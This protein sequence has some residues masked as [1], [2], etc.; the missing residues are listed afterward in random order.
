VIFERNQI[1]PPCFG[2]KFRKT[3][4]FQ[5]QVFKLLFEKTYTQCV[6]IEV[7]IPVLQRKE[8]Q[9]IDVAK[10]QFIDC[11]SAVIEDI[12]MEMKIGDFKYNY[13]YHKRYLY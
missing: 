6:F 7:N 4:F 8:I 13:T 10:R 5:P 9:V 3:R 12:R 11:R 1:K 2:W